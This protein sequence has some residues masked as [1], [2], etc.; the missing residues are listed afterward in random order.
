MVHMELK[1]DRS[2]KMSYDY[3]D[4]PIISRRLL[5]SSYPNYSAPIHWHDDIEMIAILSGEAQYNINGEISVLSKGEGILVNARQMH[6]GFSEEKKECD[7]LCV[8]IHPLL[9]CATPALERDFVLPLINNRNAAFTKLHADIPWQKEIYNEICRIH[10][11]REEKNAPMKILISFAQI[12]TL[13]YE[14]T[15]LENY[16]KP[17]NPELTIVKNII[18]F[19]QQNYAQK[20][21]LADIAASGTVGQSKCC[22][23]FAKYLRQ[24]PNMYLTQYRLDKSTELLKSTNM[25]ITEIALE[26]GFG[27]ASYYAEIFRKCF[28]L[29]PTEYRKR[30]LIV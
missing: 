12:W 20:L 4:Y 27:G 17:Q 5:L 3:S 29:S 13:L 18:G 28:G 2:E 23:L 10:S 19:I 6:F 8:L 9:L 7:F 22:K 30:T 26:T 14:N 25:T 1:D 15:P 24:T 11:V 16:P 21:S